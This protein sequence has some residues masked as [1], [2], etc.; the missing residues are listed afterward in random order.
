MSE[1]TNPAPPSVSAAPA[2]DTREQVAPAS[3]WQKILLFLF[4]LLVAGV[5]LRETYRTIQLFNQG[6]SAE[7]VAEWELPAGARLKPGPAN[8]RYDAHH[9]MLRYRGLLDAQQQ[10]QLRD[11]LEF[12][13]GDQATA[14]Q[15]PAAGAAAQPPGSAVEQAANARVG[16]ARPASSSAARQ[17]PMSSSAAAAAATVSPALATAASAASP[18]STSLQTT[19]RSYYSAIDSLAFASGTGQVTQLQL[20]LLLGL[21]GGALGAIL[22]SL[23]DFVGHA[24]YTGKLDLHRWWPLYATRPLVGSILGFLLVVLFKARLLSAA[25]AQPIDDSFWW[26]GMA[27]IGGF[28]TVDVTLRLRMA[29]KALFGV[30]SGGQAS[31]KK[32]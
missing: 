8:F 2:I 11:L 32:G 30:E 7:S 9:K 16:L 31:G 6:A 25:A 15:K 23:V 14:A 24:C 12:E 20:L 4:L 21:L 17:P 18:V 19:Q 22:R 5:L 13:G 10:L 28:S 27:A 29:A 26:L 1:D 3:T